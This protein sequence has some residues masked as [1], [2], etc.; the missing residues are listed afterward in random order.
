[1]KNIYNLTITLILISTY[2]LP[3]VEI[4]NKTKMS[5]TDL[6]ANI[7]TS[8]QEIETVSTK[9]SIIQINNV[10]YQQIEYQNHFFYIKLLSPQDD[11][12]QTKD[13]CLRRPLGEAPDRIKFVLGNE[14]VKNRSHFFIQSLSLKCGENIDWKTFLSKL[15]DIKLGMSLPEEK[16]DT[17]KDKSLFYSPFLNSLNMKGSF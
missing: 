2:N 11:N 14:E 8:N 4:K 13:E 9:E 6:K 5:L 15:K 10:P 17:L 3:A 16:N 12:V 1:M 7:S